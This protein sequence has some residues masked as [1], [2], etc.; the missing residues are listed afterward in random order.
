MA[1]VDLCLG[2]DLEVWPF[3]VKKAKIEGHL[4]H[5]GEWKV[6]DSESV[7]IPF[8]KGLPSLKLT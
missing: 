8:Q 7:G 2:G 4:F 3:F 1:K 6:K 5:G